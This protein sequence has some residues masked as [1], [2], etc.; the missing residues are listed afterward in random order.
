MELNSVEAH[1]PND[2]YML[3]RGQL[4]QEMYAL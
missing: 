4:L 2:C 1:L 3:L